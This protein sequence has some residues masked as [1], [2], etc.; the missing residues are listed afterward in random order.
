M[1][2]LRH[3]RLYTALLISVIWLGP[4]RAQTGSESSVG[5]VDSALPRTQYRLRF[6][7]AYRDNSPERAEFFYSRASL[8]AKNETGVDYQEQANYFEKAWQ[9]RF[10]T[11]LEVPERFLNPQVNSDTAGLGD[12][13]T[14]F[15]YAFRFDPTRVST[16]QTRVYVPTGNTIRG[17]GTG[18]ASLEP[19]LLQYQRLSQ[20]LFLE[21]EL[22]LWIPAGG[23]SF[24][25]NI[26]R[27]GGGAS[28][29]IVDRPGGWVAPVTEVVGWTVLNGRQ[30]I[31]PPG[32]E[33]SAAGET[34]VNAKF[35]VRLGWAPR[36]F[37]GG[38][39]YVGYG[40]A[41]TG[42]VWYKDILR[43]ELRL[44]Y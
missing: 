11:F 39:F 42:A 19:A 38:D 7:A 6:D 2:W 32:G 25:G 3:L 33:L 36:Y 28:Y 18:H 15:K 1:G 10:S 20:R 8:P 31:F 24:A 16:L 22:R 40:R 23:S 43:V 44:R 12:I 9:P 13:N 35:G 26:L 29:R 27:Y 21:E 5:Y 17:L 4:V 41:L 30:E 14:G 37:Q 34:I